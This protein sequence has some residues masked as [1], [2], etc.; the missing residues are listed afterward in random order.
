MD[1]GVANCERLWALPLDGPR[2]DFLSATALQRPSCCLR[3]PFTQETQAFLPPSNSLARL[4]D[5]CN[6][7]KA[8][9]RFFIPAFICMV[10]FCKGLHTFKS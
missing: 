7:V 2:P 8:Y 10:P 9:V 3:P 1:R 5:S 4:N 6:F